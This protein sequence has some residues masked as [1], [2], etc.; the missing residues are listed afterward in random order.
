LA[1]ACAVFSYSSL[2]QTAPQKLNVS[3]SLFQPGGAPVTQSS[4]DFKIE[5]LDKNKTCVLYSED[6]FAQDLSASKG[7][8]SLEIGSGLNSQNYLQGNTVLSWQVFSNTGVASGAFGGCPGGVTMNPGEERFI[9]VSYN[10]G[11]GL[12][13][14]TPEVA[15]TSAAYAMVA[16]TLSGK[17]ASEFIQVK[18]DVGTDL[19]QSN[20]ETVFSAA[21]YAKLLQLL[22]NTFSAGYSFN[23]QRITSVGSPT[24]GTDA[25]NR[26]WTDTHVADKSADLSGVGAGTGQGATLIWNASANRWDTGTPLAI[27][28]TKL[29]LAGGTMSG[30]VSMG[31]NSLFNVGDISMAAQRLLQLGTYNNAQEGAL[32]LAA[33][34]RGKLMYNT[35]MSVV[36]VWNGSTWSGFAPAGA[37]GGDLSGAYPNPYINVNAVSTVKIVDNAIT[38]AKMNNALAD[39]N[40]LLTT[41]P[42][43]G[44]N[45]AFAACGLNQVMKFD[46]S[47]DWSCDTVMNIL[48]SSGVTAG[49][50]G[51]STSVGRFG[52]NSI[53]A[54]TMAVNVPINFPVTTV[55]GRTGNVTLAVADI[56]GLG[57]AALEYVGSG[58]GNVPQLDAGGK[59][60]A[61]FI[62]GGLSV[63]TLVPGNGILISGSV[64]TK[65]IAVDTGITANKILQLDSNGLLGIG[66]A[67]VTAGSILD[68]F[69]TGSNRSS[70]IVPRSTT[71]DRPVIGVD[72]MIRYNTTLAKFEVY[73]NGNWFNMATGSTGD[74]LGNHTA[75]SAIVA[76]AGAAATPGYTFTGDTDTGLWAA[77]TN[78]VAVSTGGTERMRIDSTGKVGIGT[79]SSLSNLTVHAASSP[80]LALSTSDMVNGAIQIRF[81]I[82]GTARNYIWQEYVP[83]NSV[84]DIAI[85][86]GSGATA[87]RV[88]TGGD[89]SIGGLVP[90]YDYPASTRSLSV[91]GFGTTNATTNTHLMN[92]AGVPLM[93][94]R[95]DGNVGIGT[96]T[97]GALLDIYSTGATNSAI[98]IPRDTA[99]NR[100]TGVNGMIRYNTN[101]AR[102]E[103]FENNL[104]VN[105]TPTGAGDNLGN[106]AASQA[107]VATAGTAAAPSYTF[108]GPANR[109]MWGV[110][111]G[112]V[113]F[114]T[115]S[116]E[117][118]RIDIAGNVGIGTTSPQNKLQVK[119]STFADSI[120]FTG[121][122]DTATVGTDI[123]MGSFT[124]GGTS[125]SWFGLGAD[126]YSG[127]QFTATDE[128]PILLGKP[129]YQENFS[130]FADSGK[131]RGSI[132][133]PTPRLTISPTSG[134]V[135]IGTAIPGALLDIYS[136]GATNSAVIIPR[137]TAANRPTGVNGMIRYNTNTARFEVFENNL[138]VN[139]TPTG[140]G[141][142][143]GNHVATQ[144]IL[145][146]TGTASTPGYSFSGDADT[147]M[148][149]AGANSVA[150]S[151]G[152]TERMRIDAYGNVGIGTTST[153]SKLEVNVA[154]DVQAVF[155]ATGGLNSGGIAI[156]T[157]YA[158]GGSGI[159]LRNQGNNKW[160]LFG[161]FSGTGFSIYDY[162]GAAERFRILT[163]G[164]VGIGTTTPAALLDIYSTGTTN[165]AVI[166]PRDTAAN[167][168]AGVNGMIRYN[169]STARFEVFE[170]N[171]WVNMTP[172]GAGDN[173]GNHVAT[174]AIL[175]VTGTAATPGYSFSGQS[176]VGM[177][178]AG[179]GALAFSTSSLERFRIDANGYVGIGTASPSARAHI[180]PNMNSTVGLIVQGDNNQSSSI[181][182]WQNSSGTPLASIDATGAL[183]NS[184]SDCSKYV[185]NSGGTTYIKNTGCG[186]RF[187]VVGVGVDPAIT[188][189]FTV[190]YSINSAGVVYGLSS[191]TT[192]T[193]TGGVGGFYT[194]RTANNAGVTAT[195]YGVY[196]DALN[197]SGGGSVTNSYGIYL[198]NGTAGGTNWGI[199]Q[200][201][202]NK[203]YFAGNVGIGTAT[204]VALLDIYS[205]GSTASA[206]I[207]P[208][209]TAANRPTGVNGMIRYNT[210]TARFEVF[211]NNLWVNMT[212]TGAGD[213]LGNH[214]AT[215]AI[216][217]VYG[218]AAA[219]GYS[220]GTNGNRGMYAA[221]TGALGFSAGSLERVRI[222]STGNVGIG[223]TNPNALLDVESA[224][225]ANVRVS[226][227]SGA[228][229][230]K[231]N[232]YR[233]SAINHAVVEGLGARGTAGLPSAI[234]NGDVLLRMAASG[235]DGSTYYGGGGDDS[236]SI[237]MAADEDFT[238]VNNHGGRIGFHTLNTN[239]LWQVE[240]MTIRSNGKVG[241][242]TV[243]PIAEL[244]VYGTGAIVV[245]R[246]SSAVRPFGVN[247]M[248][249]YNTNT[250]RFEVFEN[251]LWVNMTPTGSGDNLGNHTATQAILATVGTA[252]TPSY[253]FA[254]GSNRGMYAAGTGALAFSTSSLE[255][256]RIDAAGNV[257][258]GT[259]F[260]SEKLTI[261]GNIDM[262]S[263]RSILFDSGHGIISEASGQLRLNGS[264]AISLLQD[265]Y[266]NDKS[267]YF[268]AVG[269]AAARIDYNRVNSN[270]GDVYFRT[271]AGGI[272]SD[273]LTLHRS[274]SV[275]I[276]TVTPGALLDVYSTGATNSSIIIPRDT[277]ANRP[278]GVNGMIRY[279]TNS[280][281]FEAFQNGGWL[282]IVST[283]GGV[284]DNLGNH[285]A[286]QAIVAIAGTA[287][288]PSYTFAGDNDTG[289]S[290][291]GDG[292]IA[293]ST[294]A[295]ERIRIA[296][297]GY[298]GIGMNNPNATLSVNGNQSN[299]YGSN[300]SYTGS[301]A[302]FYPTSGLTISNGNSADGNGAFIGF[303][304][305]PAVSTNE[306][307][308]IGALATPGTGNYTPSLVF[309]SSSI[310]GYNERMRINQDGFLGVGTTAPL[311]NLDIT[312]TGA[313]VVPRSTT[314][315]RPFGINGMIR[316]NSDNNK[317][318]VYQGLWM[319]MITAQASGADNL[320]DHTA[321]TSIL[322]VTGTAATPSYTFNGQP[323]MGM[324]A[325]GTGALAFSTSSLEQMR[326]DS[327]GNIGLGISA[328]TADLHLDNGDA[329]A[330]IQ[331][332]TAGTSTGR[333]VSD[334]FEI[335]LDSTGNADIRQ[336]ENKNLNFYQ[337]NSKIMEFYSGQ[338]WFLTTTVGMNSG[339]SVVYTP[340]GAG[341]KPGLP[342][343]GAGNNAL[344]DG[345][346]SLLGMT[347]R[348]SAGTYQA[349]YMGAISNPTG[350]TPTII[351][352]SQSDS[353]AYSEKMRISAEGNVGIGTTAPA[354]LLDIY[355]TGTTASAIVIPRD[356]AANR[357]TGVNGM[358]R[359]NTNSA[360]FEAF[361]NGG[362]LDIVST[363]GGVGDNLGNHTANQAILGVNGTAATP[364]YS[365]GAN[366]NRGM[367]A[368][369]TGSLAF[370]TS[371]LERFRID[372]NG[373]VGVGT[374]TPAAALDVVGAIRSWNSGS[375][376]GVSILSL[377]DASNGYMFAQI[378]GNIYWNG[379]DWITGTDGS[380]SGATMIATQYSGAMSFYTFPSVGGTNQTFSHAN[381]LARERM[382][383]LGNGN[384]GIGTTAP[385]AH[386]DVV[387]TGAIIV[388]RDTAATRP[389]GI[390]GMIRFN[391]TLQKFE[392]YQGLWLDMISAG[393][394]ASDNLGNHTATTSILAVSGT[395]A[396]PS[397]SFGANGN[398]G[399]YAMG[400]GSLAFSTG[401]LDRVVVD[402]AG[403]VGIG[404]TAPGAMLQ[405]AGY[406]N[407]QGLVVTSRPWFH[408]NSAVVYTPTSTSMAG[409][410]SAALLNNTDST[411]G[412]ASSIFITTKNNTAGAFVGAIAP[413]AGNTPAIVIGQQTGA[414]AYAERI[415]IDATGNLGIGT[416]SPSAILDIFSTGGT[417][418]AIIVPRDIAANRPTGVNGMIRY[419]NT[420][421]KFEVYQ[422]L[423]LDMLSAG[424]GASDNLGDHTATTSILAVTGTAATPSYSFADNGNRGMW[425]AG[426]GG[427]AFSTSSLE[428]LRVDST[429][430]VGIGTSVPEF[431]LSIGDN[432]GLSD[433]SILA[434]GAVGSG[435]VLST[436]GVGTRM[437]WYP[438]KGAFRAGHSVGT[439]WDDANIG[440]YSFAGGY[441]SLASADGATAF[442]G[443]RAQGG[444]SQAI[445]WNTM[446]SAPGGY[447]T[448]IGVDS[449]V[450]AGKSQAL[451]YGLT[452]SG[453]YS[454][455]LGSFITTTGSGAFGIGATGYNTISGAAP[456]ISGNHSVGIFMGDQSGK[457][458][459]ADNV[460]SV[461]G[462][463]MVIGNTVP[464]TGAILDVDGTGASFSSM[465]VPRD[466]AANRPVAGVN[467]MIRFNSTSN[468][469]EVYQGLW[470][471]MLSAG[472]GGGSDN[473]GN[474]T[475]T[476][477]I[478]AVTG[479][480]ATPSY[481]FSGDTDT[482]L[483][484][485]GTNRIGF[486]T[487]GTQRIRVDEFGFVGIGT[488]NP[489]WPF[490]S[491]IGAA[492]F[493]QNSTSS[494]V[495]L[496]TDNQAGGA[497]TGLNSG[498]GNDDIRINSSGGNVVV[499]NTGQPS[500]NKFEVAG[501]A[502]IGTFGAATAPTNGLLVAGNVGIGSTSPGARLDIFAT[503]ASSAII[504]PRDTAANRPTGVNGMI[505]Y[506]TTSNKFE[507][508]QGLWQDMLSASAGG[509]D[510]LGNHTATSQI[511]A[512][513][514]TG[515]NPGYSFAGDPN[516][517]M[518]AIGPDAIGFETGGSPRARIDN[519]GVFFGNT[520][521]GLS[522]SG[523]SPFTVY[524]NSYTTGIFGPANTGTNTVNTM[525]RF[526]NAQYTALDIG[527]QAGTPYGIWLQNN[528]ATDL[529]VKYP[530]MLNPNGGAVTIGTTGAAVETLDLRGNIHL[531]VSN[532]G[533]GTIRTERELVMRQ[534]G[535]T[536]GSTILR[537]RNRNN[538][539]GVI[540]ETNDV[541]A[542]LVD[543]ILKTN[544]SQR[545]FRL[546]GRA[547]GVAGQP[548]FHIGGTNPDNPTLGVGDSR[549][550]VTAPRFDFYG[551]GTTGT[552]SDF[553]VQAQ[554][555]TSSG[556]GGKIYLHPGMSGNEGLVIIGSANL[557][558][559]FYAAGPNALVITG[560]YDD[561]FNSG[562]I[563]LANGR[564]TPANNDQLGRLNFNSLN[565]G[566][567][568]SR[569]KA[570]IE[571][572]AE[573]SSGGSFG[574]GGNLVFNTKVDGGGS[575]LERM[576]ISGNGQVGINTSSPVAG[577]ILDIRS[578]S[579]AQSSIV[580]PR[581]TQANRPATG[582]NGMIRYN[583]TSQKF[584]VYEGAWQNMVSGG[585]KAVTTASCTI[586]A[587]NNCTA[588]C[589]A[590]YLR[591]GCSTVASSGGNVCTAAPSGSDACYCTELTGNS[592]GNT[593]YA[594]C[595]Q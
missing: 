589:P 373:N 187:P 235:W 506:N 562:V 522:S 19:N 396:T 86:N 505:R 10:L 350:Y 423:W 582:V 491:R 557:T 345:N 115:G 471:D 106:H 321:T 167:R 464:I 241:I 552:A 184:V 5:I 568:S 30:P 346:G 104:W 446:V 2:G 529:S 515:A 284:S 182:Q 151:T 453:P 509:S 68:I 169:I 553:Y 475:A 390:N 283:G 255:R 76:I 405:V 31:A 27:D 287:A 252:A 493:S 428:R 231:L 339:N 240:R 14:M 59:I 85:G 72:G 142:N 578:T 414:T 356:T 222:D 285:L 584:E 292:G 504:I 485:L 593:C 404:T 514:G 21:N 382:T 276:G 92:A 370:S 527:V 362:W 90:G 300:Q 534:D 403:N 375:G 429:G 160:G 198:A 149:A 161:P 401:S 51:S 214:T 503:G 78:A 556:T 347:G 361:Q 280:S 50:Y 290:N 416:S 581:D 365:F 250:S 105:M 163:N 331:R 38:V 444:W 587:G 116:S 383:I 541:T 305:R 171:M 524:R 122:S 328:P 207:I 243:A 478:M 129:Y 448:A 303:L 201:D 419:N 334:G 410:N 256:V 439:Q 358:I 500:V 298:V 127:G 566:T 158:A 355:S 433:G 259:A 579:A 36:R 91:L 294:N 220:F 39:T 432:S 415:R 153:N 435:G 190:D 547:T 236:A 360:K 239:D 247:G 98:I 571:S 457:V 354:A 270:T 181:Q 330:V 309:G 271:A 196:V 482:G 542:N 134:N 511:L 393:G 296:P 352:G 459:A 518:W 502:S 230:L 267:F 82:L 496:G 293:L 166:V 227:S 13:A 322:A 1:L 512:T 55:A 84:N 517:G 472:G 237:T 53:G 483:W 312:G 111:T 44:T 136:T 96:A 62:P 135:G 216:L 388:P 594:Y 460:M 481:T 348:N 583:T 297:N 530:I 112:A 299:W 37:A 336:R 374:A 121:H 474:H 260:T 35:D 577:A 213:N 192:N 60:P 498:G 93:L 455:G 523:G 531:A 376:T 94:V 117:R 23:G 18:D 469:F 145:G 467:G 508:Y 74:N 387:G 349:A 144:A 199:Y 138:W 244:D 234:L 257:G 232:S 58:A 137:D 437:I 499:G 386:L 550:V 28:G 219:P 189:A 69:S 495:L 525:A 427:L 422:G 580:I 359:Y 45:V 454:T 544:T 218:T 80:T 108:E 11:S 89:I 521:S 33:G 130:I 61:A 223:T 156:D 338:A 488:T 253:A 343:I 452:I 165:S 484:N 480:A 49:E 229:G 56:A 191:T 12:T 16:D 286:S 174:Q 277:S 110:G 123:T 238:G 73:E 364:S 87:F 248:I 570:S 118:L 308:Y 402:A 313:I 168:P 420:S 70:M 543:L 254:D 245:P 366:G 320:G 205:T 67:S 377:P 63:E 549:V 262:I 6:H 185:L 124:T 442:G 246:N 449:S 533:T 436:A 268:G 385:L 66:T 295:T 381:L 379:T 430:K 363:G 317:F 29:P 139:M 132:Y 288:T 307:A 119:A 434:M 323:N 526:L 327:T 418:S 372:S 81:D 24:A 351:I 251:N 394:G 175:G 173:L 507:V 15:V 408:T 178:L 3:G 451:G 133:T 497:I 333:T 558:S 281:K 563:M 470:M 25:V 22:N 211:E 226:A 7:G 194:A 519:N 100:P 520:S 224:T 304:A 109:G 41:D 46:A 468:K 465:I 316:Y 342:I 146:V 443:G 306:T 314:A 289:M 42:T 8:F 272:Y 367:Y 278:T 411:T 302:G 326:I 162:V 311:S 412:S 398:R 528:S 154:N 564:A 40:K 324:S 32:T 126:Y 208:R 34:D 575:Y 329:T 494:G 476:T 170:N 197:V 516:T 560:R 501:N 17:L 221:G 141:D 188:N 75:T 513:V 344:Q 573:G 131:T 417:N 397:Y 551:G 450:N 242:G 177:S 195:S 97:P 590:G 532:Q 353:S 425:A 204:P 441:S 147:G 473:L 263:D 77:G 83:A 274:G 228:A 261:N 395:A 186:A 275:G 447:S 407:S 179:T 378:G 421:Q 266:L 486:S 490:D 431:P 548:S 539:N 88:G 150:V 101:T 574:Y 567:F 258:I 265:T 113:A 4:V 340:T 200:A 202:A 47:G 458:V 291:V 120:T 369:G 569:T 99:A 392:V 487:G 565:N 54:V 26:N 585:V 319:D 335:G 413:A 389:F 65:T 48:G 315:N 572:W 212:P 554:H 545:N 332:F 438:R 159:V 489:V 140:S 43:T 479:T 440:L 510:N 20:V 215:Q 102:F 209:D 273:T 546:E 183:I 371:S 341:Y 64:A 538:E 559:P 318:E 233:N 540:L 217:A 492:F 176:N 461:L 52:V 9:R 535:D 477:S 125:Y 114:S 384:V 445:G 595:S 157:D 269:D 210:N 586:A 555:H 424:G 588:T 462:G 282:D 203:N 576:R 591:T 325:A 592:G 399:M 400:T 537:L 426:T 95:N 279:N 466:T 368:A 463:R 249:R 152:G 172:T 357:P 103:V 164:N 380:N 406:I 456:L 561:Q 79:A 409:P 107:I 180:Y 536:Y 71:A 148:W 225:D 301:G 206:I 155:K 391:T 128:G 193:G 143:L 57:S 337:N 264:S 310:T